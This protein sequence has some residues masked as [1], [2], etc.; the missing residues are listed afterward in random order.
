LLSAKRQ[1]SQAL[2]VRLITIDYNSGLRDRRLELRARL[3][4]LLASLQSYP[5][6]RATPRH[7]GAL[8]QFSTH[9]C[10]ALSRL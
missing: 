5:P 9:T 2:W 1:W 6:P 10:A 7:D 3:F 8:L 4:W